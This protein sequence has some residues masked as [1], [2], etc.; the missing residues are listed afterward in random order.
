[1][2]DNLKNSAFEWKHLTFLKSVYVLK[3]RVTK[4][5]PYINAE[6]VVESN[7]H[8]SAELLCVLEKSPWSWT[9][10]SPSKPIFLLY[11]SGSSCITITIIYVSDCC[12]LPYY[13]CLNLMNH[14]VKRLG[15]SSQLYIYEVTTNG[16]NLII[17]LSAFVLDTNTPCV[18]KQT[19]ISVVLSFLFD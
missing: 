5:L 16:I 13:P 1:M 14:L 11:V 6:L 10:V 17:L 15:C 8:K 19:E 2:H 9:A 18:Y 7:W 3:W 4:F 12:I